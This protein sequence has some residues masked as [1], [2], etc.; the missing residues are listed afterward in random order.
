[1]VEVKSAVNQV[2][3]DDPQRFLLPDVFFIQRA[4]MDENLRRPRAGLRLEANAQ[5]A[6]APFAAR[7]NGVGEGKKSCFASARFFKTFE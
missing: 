6:I 4:H 3:A 2:N 7:R 1:M 5:P